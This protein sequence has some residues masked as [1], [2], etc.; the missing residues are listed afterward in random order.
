MVTKLTVFHL[1]LTV[2][3]VFTDTS[4]VLLRAKRLLDALNHTAQVMQ[5]LKDVCVLLWQT[6]LHVLET[7]VKEG[8]TVSCQM[9]CRCLCYSSNKYWTQ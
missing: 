9:S 1:V 6:H 8:K 2:Q 7:L 4:R 3:K 5:G